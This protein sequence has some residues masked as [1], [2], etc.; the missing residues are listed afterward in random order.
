LE[1]GV[2][3]IE[4][5]NL[6]DATTPALF[7]KH[8]AFYVP[9]LVTYSA[10]AEHGRAYG[11]SE[12]SYGKIFDVLESGRRALELAHQ[13]GVPIAY[14]TDLLGPMHRFQSREFTLRAEVQPPAAILRG[15]TTVAARLLRLEGQVG[16]I[17]PGAWADVLVVDGNPLEDLGVLADPERHIALIMQGGR[18]V[19]DR[20]S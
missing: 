17:V 16:A 11:L 12:T 14:G 2:R 10:L 8:G 4:H 15:A 9:T 6:M 18:L 5:G 13:A 1:C 20:L 7:L 19:R 3:S